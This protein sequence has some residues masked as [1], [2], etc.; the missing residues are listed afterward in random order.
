MLLASPSSHSPASKWVRATAALLLSMFV[1]APASVADIVTLKNGKKI[2]GKITSD[3]GGN[4]EIQTKFGPMKVARGDVAKIERMR[5]PK[6]ELA[7]MVEDAGEDAVLLWR[8]VEFAKKNKL[9]REVKAILEK[10]VAADPAHPDANK[11]LGRIYYN[12]K[13]YSP[14]ELDSAKSAEATKMEA[15]GRIFH[16][17][18]WLKKE[19]V[20]RIRGFEEY[21]GEWLKW[22]DIYLLEAEEKMP[23]YLGVALEGRPSEHYILW[24]ELDPGLQADVLDVLETGFQHFVSVFQPTAIE[25]NMMTFYPTAVYVLPS[26]DLVAT[27]AEDNGY[28]VSLYNP[29]K[30]I[31]SRYLDATSF[32]VF[33]PRPLIV[34]SSGRHLKGGGDKATSLMGFLTHFSG[35][36]MLR[37]FKRGGKIPGWV[38]SGVTHFYEGLLNG[39]R[40]LTITDYVGYEHIEKWV[41]GLSDFKEWYSK[42]ADPAFR[43]SLPRLGS[44]KGK[45]A[46]ELTGQELC[47]AYFLVRWLMETEQRTPTFID[48][49]RMAYDDPN[50]IRVTIPE[51]EAFKATFGVDAEVLEEEFEIWASRLPS[52][53]PVD[54]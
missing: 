26:S 1:L 23:E 30:N 18:K 34:T 24:S 45:F 2:E 51:D 49:V 19:T 43:R 3:G 37:R 54:G 17:G 7:K 27:F 46:E 8:T 9:K 28:M 4:I 5:L 13:W 11:E 36:V 42:I 44:F 39:H 22:K 6:E 40:T 15:E 14:E 20:M 53:P 21:K 35:N 32:P 41:M 29:P 52:N 33:F 10:V 31:N 48:Y 38:E 25:L 16:E 50:K 47:K 12:G